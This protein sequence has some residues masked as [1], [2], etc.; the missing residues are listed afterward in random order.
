[1]DFSYHVPSSLSISEFLGN[2]NHDLYVKVGEFLHHGRYFQ[3]RVENDIA[4]YQRRAEVS[5]LTR[6]NLV[7]S[8]L[9]SKRSRVSLGLGTRGGGRERV[10]AAAA[11]EVEEEVGRRPRLGGVVSG[12][13][14]VEVA[15]V[16]KVG[17]GSL[18]GEGGEH[19]ERERRNEIEEEE[20]IEKE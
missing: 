9:N 7:F 15:V 14:M 3:Y 17:R 12:E 13:E 4:S 6:G 16:T 18:V 20:A 10:E 2:D 11:A 19:N 1:M 5:D 8:S